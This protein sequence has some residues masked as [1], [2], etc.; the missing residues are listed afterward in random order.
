MEE[1]SPPILVAQISAADMD[2][3]ENGQISYKLLDDFDGSFEI[4]ANS[5]E[6]Y[7]QAKL[8]RESVASYELTVIAED[9]VTISCSTSSNCAKFY[10]VLF[11]GVPQLTGTATVLVTVLDKNDNPPRF[12]R[13]FSVNVTE[14]AEIGSF[15]I[16]VTSSDQ[17][18][19]ENANATYSFT[20][21]PGEK[22]KI[23]PITGNVTVVGE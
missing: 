14:N 11:Q 3:G 21:N 13:L 8:D 12:T 18:I 15:V 22:F 4:D 1:E 17:D 23:D 19:G 20:E 7:T 6:I 5:G 2:S 9:Q 10:H 16:R